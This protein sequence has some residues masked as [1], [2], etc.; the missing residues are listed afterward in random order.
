MLH[1]LALIVTTLPSA[2]TNG[3][4]FYTPD[5][6]GR[7]VRIWLDTDGDGF[8]T[9]NAARSLRLEVD[10][11]RARFPV[12]AGLV[13][14]LASDGFLPLFDGSISDRIFEG[15][16]A[17]FGETWFAGRITRFDYRRKT[18]SLLDAVPVTAGRLGRAEIA[19]PHSLIVTVNGENIAMAL[20][21]A[22]TVVLGDVAESRM[23]DSWGAVRATSFLRS[24]VM[25]KWHAANPRWPYVPNAGAGGV[26]ALCVPQLT[27]GSYRA[28]NVWFSTRPKDDVFEGETVSGKI[29]PTAFRDA[30]LTLDY[31]NRMAYFD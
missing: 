31:L 26:A 6:R 30:V 8:I 21:I 14:P 12:G 20:D 3:R 15:I 25:A 5:V 22:A 2:L 17:Q 9:Y 19:A 10:G 11:R 29:G 4:F 16:D 7:Q 28:V 27:V 1:V 13:T 23:H 24:D 18:L